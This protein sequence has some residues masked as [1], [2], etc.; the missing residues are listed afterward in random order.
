MQGSGIRDQGPGVRDD[1]CIRV[2]IRCHRAQ[3]NLAESKT[4]RSATAPD[5]WPPT[6]GPYLLLRSQERVERLIGFA[7]A[8][9]L[10]VSHLG[11]R[12]GRQALQRE[13]VLVLCDLV[14]QRE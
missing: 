12:L 7:G 4:A 13:I 1:H 10:R 2:E 6:P 8:L 14:E 5:P 3:V 9:G 11:R